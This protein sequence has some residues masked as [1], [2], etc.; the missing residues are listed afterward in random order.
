MKK[1]ILHIFIYALFFLTLGFFNS[2]HIPQI[3]K[4]VRN[5][6]TLQSEKR[7]PVRILVND[8]GFSLLPLGLELREIQIL[9]KGELSKQ[10]APLHI[11]RAVGGFHFFNV[12]TGSRNIVDISIFHPQATVIQKKQKN[13]ASLRF[14]DYDFD[15]PIEKLLTLPFHNISLFNSLLRFKSENAEISTEIS[16]LDLSVDFTGKSIGLQLQTPEFRFRKEDLSRH[17]KKIAL[18]LQSI[19]D[20]NSL[21]ISSLKIQRGDSTIIGAGFFEGDVQKLHFTNSSIKGRLNID[22]EEALHF[23]SDYIKKYDLPSVRGLLDTSFQFTKSS[24]NEWTG[25]AQ[26][27]TRQLA[28]NEY[29]IGEITTEFNYENSALSFPE[30]SVSN[31]A[32]E[33]RLE[34][35]QIDFKD[36]YSFNTTVDIRSLEI[37][38]LLLQL[39]LPKSPLVIHTTGK[40]PCKGSLKP[41]VSVD[42]TGILRGFD[43]RIF[44]KDKPTKTIVAIKDFKIDG[45]VHI[46]EKGIYPKA[47]LS[48]GSSKGYAEGEILYKSGFQFRYNTPEL[49]MK[50]VENLADLKF[51]GA[52]E[53][54]GSTKGNADYATVDLDMRTRDFWFEDFAIG[55]SGAKLEYKSGILSFK[56]IKGNYRTS[57]FLGEV[58]VNI[59]NKSV[60]ANVQAPVVEIND[61]QKGLVRKAQL[62][63]QAYGVGSG[64]IDL[65]G[66]LEFTAL[67]YKVQSQFN[68][69][70]IGPESFDKA[71]F[72]VQATHG[73][74]VAEKVEITKGAGKFVLHGKGFPNGQIDLSIN[75]QGLQIEDFQT[76]TDKGVGL[77][78]FITSDVTLKGYVFTPNVHFTA[79]T[80]HVMMVN[81]PLQDSKADFHINQS[82][83]EGKAEF[84]GDRIRTEFIFPLEENRP[85]KLN[86]ATQKWD[87]APLFNLI[88]TNVRQQNYDT[89]L[90]ANVKLESASGGY[91]KSTGVIQIDQ[92]RVRRNALQFQNVDPIL[93]QLDSGGIE[94]KKFLIRGDNTDLRAESKS[95]VPGAST[96]A[97]G[98]SVDMSLLSFLTPFLQEL[99]GVLS[100]KS[101]IRLLE[102]GLSIQGSAFIDHAYAQMKDF[103]HPL[104]QIRADALFTENRVNINSASANFA[105]GKLYADGAIR[106]EGYKKFPATISLRLEDTTIRV[107]N[108][109]SSK[110]SGNATITGSWFPY[111][112]EGNYTVTEGLLDRAFEP[113]QQNIVRRSSYLPKI[114]LQDVFD[115]VEFS[116]QTHINGTYQVKNAL[117]DSLV[118][119]SLLIKGTPSNPALLGEIRPVKGGQIFFRDTPFT[120]SNGS[121]RFDSVNDLNPFIFGS[122]TARVKSREYDTSPSTTTPANGNANTTP[123]PE[124]RARTRDYDVNLLIQGRMKSLKITLTSQ[125]P[126]EEYDIISLLALGVTSQQLEKRQSGDQATDLG[127]AILSQNLALKNK[128]FDVKISSSSAAED[129][130]VGDSKVTLSRQWTQK[131]STSVGRTFRSNVTDAKLKYDLNDNLAAILNWEGRQQAEETN[132]QTKKTVNDVLGV[133]L[134]YGVEFK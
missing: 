103:P 28:I 55:N 27:K 24:G 29:K 82:S 49:D 128:L 52:T 127:S 73:N 13:E 8:I 131:M 58:V 47:D 4:W 34:K 40:I 97:F 92:L 71:F 122:A 98:G 102:S 45:S 35:P 107:P 132:Q 15:I 39:G 57:Q 129:T 101:Q 14:A 42:C 89:E 88:S 48:L 64:S 114:L 95:T 54:R 53:I 115:P 100:I 80:S 130:N 5:Q 117:V 10:M 104:E 87:F 94:V 109:V 78:G 68:Q 12:L 108:G 62:P 6:I 93:V 20:T 25:G 106:I 86:I 90:T 134:E 84:I 67:T 21:Q 51:E 111:L 125:P 119:G 96:V 16:G 121:V 91:K 17:L 118:T 83:L 50:N 1:N 44:D 69:G 18:E 7:L 76:I 75:G 36:K 46:D 32:G 105:G 123:A 77:T 33:I 74:V 63:F 9:P 126:L 37:A 79:Q 22:I 61:I 124:P 41:S 31:D 66:P 11:D 133:G 112:M 113:E 26:L 3:K 99:R 116:I 56:N 85:F 19:V 59:P 38:Q 120:I 23:A 30:L 110:G 2:Y 70:F 65:E 60:K 81:Q 72:N 43:T